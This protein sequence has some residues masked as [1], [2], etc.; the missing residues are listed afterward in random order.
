MTKKKTGA[1]QEQQEEQYDSLVNH[2]YNNC[3]SFI[4]DKTRHW[5]H[6][7]EVMDTLLSLETND[8]EGEKQIVIAK[9]HVAEVMLSSILE[10]EGLFGAMCNQ[11][12]LLAA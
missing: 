10:M 11:G 5:P 4:N 9:G 6:L 12:D 8:E 2:E 1:K 3:T 7:A